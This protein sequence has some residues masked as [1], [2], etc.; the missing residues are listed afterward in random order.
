[1]LTAHFSSANLSSNRVFFIHSWRNVL[2]VSAKIE[3]KFDFIEPGINLKYHYEIRRTE[4][5]KAQG[6]HFLLRSLVLQMWS[7]LR[8]KGPINHAALFKF[9]SIAA[10]LSW[11]GD[12]AWAKSV[13][14]RRPWRAGSPPV[15]FW[16]QSIRLIDAHLMRTVAQQDSDQKFITRCMYR[17]VKVVV[18]LSSFAQSLTRLL[19]LKPAVFVG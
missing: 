8:K 2:A 3:Y 16:M 13:I 4:K 11:F 12:Y 19:I 1:M 17:L 6:R 7:S 10:L 18:L 15:V 9:D 5:M 14:P